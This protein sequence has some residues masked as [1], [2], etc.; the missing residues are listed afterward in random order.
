MQYTPH[1][2]QNM[3]KK[4]RHIE[5]LD[6]RHLIVTDINKLEINWENLQQFVVWKYSNHYMKISDDDTTHCATY[7]IGE[8]CLHEND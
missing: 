4:L 8:T 6:N 5:E 2:F 1:T 3:Q 7:A